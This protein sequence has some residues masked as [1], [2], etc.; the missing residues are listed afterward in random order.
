MFDRPP[1]RVPGRLACLGQLS[2]LAN[3]SAARGARSAIVVNSPMRL[4]FILAVIVG[5]PV[6]AVSGGL[7]A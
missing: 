7:R 2:C 6:P 1:T 4:G 3:P 5:F